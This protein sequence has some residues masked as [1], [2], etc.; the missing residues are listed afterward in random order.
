MA[1]DSWKVL[2]CDCEGT[3]PLD[4]KR[5]AAALDS[6]LSGPATNL[7]RRQLD[8]FET[9]LQGSSPILVGCTQEAP[10]FL[11]TAEGKNFEP[12]LRFTNIREKSGWS[13][14]GRDAAPK[15]AALLAEAMLNIGGPGS[16]T[17]E[18]DGVVLVMGRDQVAVDAARR[19]GERMDVT[20]VLVGAVAEI[21]PPRTVEVPIFHAE[22][23]EA[24]G[25]FGNFLITFQSFA[26]AEA[27]SK[28]SLVFEP[29]P[30][31]IG[32]S[33]ADI[34]LDLRGDTPLFS[35]PKKRDGYL[36][37]DPGD[38]LAVATALFEITDFAGAF[39][40]PSYV[41]Y[42]GS[43]CAH[44]R[45]QIIGCSRCLDSCPTGAI[46]PDGDGVAIDSY[47]CAGCGNC[48]SVCPTGAA[49]YALPRAD[50]LSRRLRTL[51]TTYEIAGGKNPA[52]LFHDME[53]GEEMI[54]TIARYYDGLPSNVIPVAVNAAT[55]IGLDTLLAAGAFG[56]GAVRILL[57]PQ[58]S[59]ETDGLVDAA[60]LANHILSGLGHAGGFVELV[61][62]S[63]PESVARTLWR[64]AGLKD[65]PVPGAMFTPVG[66]KRGLLTLSLGALHAEAPNPVD[67]MTLPDGAPFG[68][69][70]VNLDTCTLCLSCVGACPANA[71]QDNP[72][73]PRLSFVEN[74]CVQ[75]GLCVKTCP[76]DAIAL[77]PRIDFTN[78]ALNAR[79]IK[80]DEPFECVKC[81]EPFGA[82]SSIES[83]VEKM[84]G[85]AMFQTAAALDRLKMCANCRVI[86]MAEAGGDPFTG[87][88][89]PLPRTTDDDLREREQARIQ[90][91]DNARSGKDGT[92]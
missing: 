31:A 6:D 75:C 15:M 90:A 81:G 42:N 18:S 26:A 51:L 36:N 45:N 47:V 35:A 38:P 77:V 79:T 61:D 10:L 33:D 53:H 25:Y 82:R 7:C 8:R 88:P 11:E 40:K 41:D 1:D 78:A 20:L 34:V 49:S 57:S 76:E 54:D 22:S 23:V 73:Y 68:S 70:D 62:D 2:I 3:N 66:D 60:N 21:S 56:A 17:L 39:E 63:D 69:L 65:V 4:E 46:M 52:L 19:L 72:E 80:E 83:V 87:A 48:A 44:S 30:S 9:A 29:S 32:K 5:I 71:L 67:A 91:N 74:A 59:G 27:S 85:H 24:V 84:S 50:A 43:L 58:D 92:E 14:Q 37:P 89:R 55:Q 16:L 12:Q 64:L 86:D 28:D 13:K